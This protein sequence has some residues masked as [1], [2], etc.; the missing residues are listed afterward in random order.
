[1]PNFE[2]YENLEK[3]AE[4]KDRTV[5]SALLVA[6]HTSVILKTLHSD[7]PNIDMIALMYH[8]FEVAKDINYPGIIKTYGLIDEQN[9]YALIQENMN[10][11]S[12]SRHLQQNRITDLSQFLKL[13]I[14]MVKILG[15]LHQSHI[16]H[17]DIKPSNFVY[18]QKSEIIKLTDFN[19][20]TKL[21]HET[22]DIVPPSKLEGT[23][24]YMAP[25][26]T[27]RMNMNMDYRAD[28]YALGVT[29]YEMLTGKLPYTFTDPLEMLHAHLASPI[30]EINNPELDSLNAHA[31]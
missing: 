8:E 13:A 11:T 15:Y 4:G 9:S 21:M 3:I 30:P 18:D 24:A 25:E 17:K 29:F 6:D 12:L 16:I 1:M 31:T 7:H 14:Q 5:Y 20:S 19:F 22:Q 27:G 26:Q 2:G 10:G 23:L 28:F